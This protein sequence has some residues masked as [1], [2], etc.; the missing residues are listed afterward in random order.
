MTTIA[1]NPWNLRAWPGRVR[2]SATGR[3]GR[4]RQV[5]LWSL[6]GL[7][8]IRL[9]APF[10]LTRIAN[11]TLADGDEVRGSI[12]GLSLGLLTCDY[13]VHDL[14]L[15]TRHDDGRWKPLLAIRE[16]RCDLEWGPL[17]RGELAGHVTVRD[18]T[19][20]LF[21]R[22]EKPL[23]D[24][25]A[26]PEER[27]P[28]KKPTT[29]PWQD[30]LRTVI[31]ARLT[32]VTITDG[33]LHFVDD[34]R[35][36]EIALS[37]IDAR[38]ENLTIPELSLSHRSP[39]TLTARTPGHGS[40]QVDGEVDLLAKAP[41]FLARAKLED[42]RLTELN[43]LTSKIENL[44]FAAGI[45]S[46]YAEVVGDGR[47]LG[48]YLKVLFHDLDVRSFGETADGGVSGFWSAVADL[49]EEVLEN[50]DKRQH[51]ARIP[52][53]GPLDDPDANVWSALGSALANAFIRALAPGF[54][55]LPR[56]ERG[57]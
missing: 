47:R 38:V 33:T 17:M 6:V 43:P 57:A 20:H 19:L 3:R 39:F 29:P 30:S 44:T 11:A 42:V 12:G 16:T 13:T 41:T 28:R 26:A 51:A 56:G 46:G 52:I 54:D 34:G 15:R 50:D 32:A 40:L 45:F 37:D 35:G 2:D 49:A 48:G 21:A 23:A 22:I 55:R 4:W 31:R 27:T 10:I 1:E 18:P 36:L 14:E 5:L 8:I 7:I 9:S 25:P 24:L 53:R